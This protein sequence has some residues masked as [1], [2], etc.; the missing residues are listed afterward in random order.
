MPRDS[1]LEGSVDERNGEGELGAAADFAFDPEAAAVGFNDVLGDGKAE[2]GAT[3]FAGT[4]GI[5]AIEALEN[6][7]LISERDADAGVGDGDDGFAS[8]RG[9]SDAD[10]SARQG[11]LDGVVEQVL[12]NFAEETGIAADGR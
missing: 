10:G 7:L 9:G 4:R 1:T 6:S 11:V 5:H 12:E 8:G 2:A 3:G